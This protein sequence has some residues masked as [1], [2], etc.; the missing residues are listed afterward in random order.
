VGRRAGDVGSCVASAERA[1]VELG[2]T[3]EKSL[4]DACEDLWAY[5]QE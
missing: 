5:L 3:T 2:W 1:A 4:R